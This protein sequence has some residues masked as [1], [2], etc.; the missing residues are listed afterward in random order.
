[1]DDQNRRPDR[2]ALLLMGAAAGLAPAACAP[3]AKAPVASLNVASQKGNTRALVEAAGVLAGA[4][5]RVAWSE[6]GAASPLL[7]ALGAN[8]VDIGGVGDA[9]FL[10]AFAA[11]ARIKAVF[12]YQTASAGGSV[13]IVT[14]TAS[15]LRSSA[16]LKGRRVATTK[17]S[18]GHFLLLRVLDRAHL[19]LDAAHTVFLS[20]GDCKAALQTGAVDAWATWAPYIGLA[21][22]HDA[23]RVLVDG[24]GL[25]AG[26]SFM[27]A[28]EAAIA[29]KRPLLTD[30][31]AR[32]AKAYAWGHANPR[33]YAAALARDT[34]MPLDVA[35]DS[36]ARQNVSPAPITPDVARAERATL[37]LFRRAGIASTS[38]AIEGAFDPS[39]NAAWSA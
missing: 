15:P 26:Y 13:A 1:M 35:A 31:V 8:A 39:F 27:A 25:F 34:G 16:D 38:T 24:R 18:V 29:V 7:E 37:D 5:Y 33:L 36:I 21:T 2:R 17:G 22:L 32:L 30:F 19:P 20:P 4:P 28:S 14:P 23:N 11:G 9:P 10:F 12:A 3:A 6:F